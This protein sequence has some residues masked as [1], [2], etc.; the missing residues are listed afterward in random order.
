VERAAAWMLGPDLG[1][2]AC[3]ALL[4]AEIVRRNA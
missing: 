1:W 4:K 3:A 2:L